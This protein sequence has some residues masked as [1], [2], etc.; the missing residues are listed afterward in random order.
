MQIERLE[1]WWLHAH[2]MQ[3]VPLWVL[4]AMHGRL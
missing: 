2:D 4:L 3:I 1:R